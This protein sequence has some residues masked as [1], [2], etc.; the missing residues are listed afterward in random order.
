MFVSSYLSLIANRHRIGAAIVLLSSQLTFVLKFFLS[1]NL[2][3][4]RERAWDQTIASRGKGPAFWQPYVE[5]WDVPPVVDVGQW[6]GLEVAK[7][8]F[9]RLILKKSEFGFSFYF[10]SG[11]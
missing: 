9:V 4:A 11:Q 6:A 8:H 7:S 3:I 5:E 1:R 10:V 2:R